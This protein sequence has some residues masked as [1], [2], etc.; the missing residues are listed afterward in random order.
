M[1]EVDPEKVEE[2]RRRLVGRNVKD[3]T[4]EAKRL[5]DELKRQARLRLPGTN[6]GLWTLSFASA[7]ANLT[8]WMG[9]MIA[10]APWWSYLVSAGLLSLVFLAIR[11]QLREP[12]E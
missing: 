11:A 2:L 12:P 7:V 5:D 9:L 10:G 6:V 1:D 3:D 4:P 8:A